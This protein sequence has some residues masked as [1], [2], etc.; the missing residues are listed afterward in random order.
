MFVVVSLI[1]LIP[2]LASV[3]IALGGSRV[4]RASRVIAVVSVG[5]S[6]GLTLCA[7]AKLLTDPN[8]LE[9]SLYELLRSGRFIVDLG[10]YVDQ[11]TVMLLLLVTGVSF[12]VQVYSSKYM[13]GDEREARFFALTTLFTFAMVTLVMSSNLLM[14]FMCWEI[15][16]ICSY[17]LISHQAQRQAAGSAATKAFLVNAIADVG[18]LCGVV[19]TFSTFETLDIQQILERAPGTSAATF[20]LLG[21]AGME[22]HVRK[23]SLLTFFLLIGCLGKSAQF[24][25]HVWLPDAM[26]APTPV[27]ALIHAATMVNA[28]PFLLIRLAPMVILSPGVMVLMA[29]IGGGTATFA[30]VVA[31]TQTDIKRIL[32]YSTISQIGF[33]IMTCGLGAFVAAAFHLVSHGFL[34]GFLFLSTGRELASSTSHRHDEH[35]PGTPRSTW[36]VYL[37]ALVLACLPPFLLF[38]G[39]YERLWTAYGSSTARI[40]FWIV[41]LLTVFFT[42]IYLFRGIAMLFLPR[43]SAV[44]QPRFL[45]VVHL[46]GVALGSLTL[47][48]VLLFVWLGFASFLAPALGA[49]TSLTVADLWPTGDSVL[50]FAVPLLVAIGGWIVGY[51]LDAKRTRLPSARAD[52]MV[53]LYVLFHNKL[54]FD[55]AYRYCL[56]EPTVQVSRW[57]W[58]VV[59]VQGIDRV[60][61]GTGRG[62]V[63]LARWI[64]Q[65]IDVRVIDRTVDEAGTRSIGLANWLWRVIDVRKIEGSVD[66]IGHAADASGRR[67]QDV[68]PR[69][70]QHHLLVLIFWLVVAIASFYWFVL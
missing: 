43:A 61:M 51:L 36:L 9:V 28:G 2:L 33:M 14:T 31:L 45:S 20:N 34:K 25:F 35:E 22:F 69:T 37:G 1:P 50:V 65:S 58:R 21:W 59:D 57:L 4:R 46:L 48:G 56:V 17:L 16:G 64:W 15:M 49:V 11:L 66:G 3:V 52:W 5:S 13:I 18:L 68:E 32:A 40:A 63:S 47:I 41:G 26:E 42:S 23:V 62:T 60:I 7:F 44:I 70:L 39:P 29:L 27:S 54:Y 67:L 6:F 12:V 8:P 30:A 53:T 10:L 38:S 55:E 19:F 24:P